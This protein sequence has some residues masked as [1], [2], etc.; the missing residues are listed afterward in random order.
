[1]RFI[2]DDIHVVPESIPAKAISKDELLTIVQTEA[3]DLRQASKNKSCPKRYLERD[4][5]M[6]E[7]YVKMILWMNKQV[8]KD[9]AYHLCMKS[10]ASDYLYNPFVRKKDVGTHLIG[11]Q[12]LPNGISFLGFIN[13]GERYNSFSILYYDGND[14]RMYTP[15][16]GNCVN[17][18]YKMTFGGEGAYHDI[19]ERALWRKYRA[20]DF[21]NEEHDWKW[22]LHTTSYKNMTPD[23]MAAEEEWRE[24]DYDDWA[25]Y[26]SNVYLAQYGLTRDTVGLNWD[27]IKDE[28]M[29]V[30]AVT[31]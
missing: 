12:T 16:R 22:A 31:N 9:N 28:L 1:M 5:D 25:W 19:N 15:L 27:A 13:R 23:E 26:A 17:A 3:N 11:F 24:K 4:E 18:D 20:C 29:Q 21:W 10:I 30:F 14:V 6:S 7:E 8:N 2:N